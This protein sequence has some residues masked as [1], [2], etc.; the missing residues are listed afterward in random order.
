MEKK[1]L[2]PR[3]WAQIT[4]WATPDFDLVDRHFALGYD[5]RP[6]LSRIKC[7]KPRFPVAIRR[8]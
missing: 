1:G 7:P 8:V 5:E 6:T 3:E 4:C 2:R